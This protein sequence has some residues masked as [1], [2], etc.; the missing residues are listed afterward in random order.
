MEI[1]PN[2]LFYP[3]LQRPAKR[4][5][6]FDSDPPPPVNQVVIFRIASSRLRAHTAYAAIKRLR[7]RPVR[8]RLGAFP[9]NISATRHPMPRRNSHRGCR[10]SVS[11]MVYDYDCFI[12]Y[13]HKDNQDTRFAQQLAGWL[14]Q[15]KLRV[16]RQRGTARQRTGQEEHSPR[17]A[18]RA[19]SRMPGDRGLV[20]QPIRAVGAASVPR[21]LRGITQGRARTPDQAR[22]GPAGARAGTSEGDQRVRRPE[23][24][25]RSLLGAVLRTH[26]HGPGA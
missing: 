11:A 18:F 15:A 19:L 16:W 25:A 23:P 4:V 6:R 26:G 8:G 5:R 17:L 13:A 12:S 20:R 22:C 7:A 14:E 10:R 21:G 24:E 1:T 3:E 2:I 9:G